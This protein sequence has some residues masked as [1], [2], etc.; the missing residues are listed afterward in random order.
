MAYY[1]ISFIPSEY[2][3][4]MSLQYVQLLRNI[5]DRIRVEFNRSPSIRHTV[6]QIWADKVHFPGF[7]A[8]HK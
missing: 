6:G 8:K 1:I 2:C 4:N 7:F 3:L 5:Y